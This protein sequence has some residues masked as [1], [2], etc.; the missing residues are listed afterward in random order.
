MESNYT[1]ANVTRV[2]QPYKVLTAQTRYS[3]KK[4]GNGKLSGTS[5]TA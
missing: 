4:S 1:H 2:Y 5:L 3:Q